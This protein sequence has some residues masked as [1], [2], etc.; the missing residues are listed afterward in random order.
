MGIVLTM[1]ERF[2]EA[3]KDKGLS[4]QDVTNAT[5]VHKSMIS[6]LENEPKD[7]K[8]RDVGYSNIV[9]LA[10]FYGVSIDWLL[11]I[12]DV[13][14]PEINLQSACKYT[15]LTEKTIAE[16]RKLCV[17]G[18]FN[19]ENEFS[20]LLEVLF[21]NGTFRF[22]LDELF[23]FYI[24]LSAMQLDTHIYT[25]ITDHYTGGR[26]FLRM[27]QGDT[28]RCANLAREEYRNRIDDILKTVNVSNRVKACIHASNANIEKDNAPTG[29][30]F[31]DHLFGAD[32]Y[33][34]KQYKSLII[35]SIVSVLREFEHAKPFDSI[36]VPPKNQ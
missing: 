8:I 36:K 27:D 17:D 20:E 33:H 24:S 18:F 11:G 15:G 2:E 13:R 35:E 32:R 12:S 28:I 3:R 9:K 10:Q 25:E 22:L 19:D 14:S 23:A 4:I 6:A 29:V 7:G 1:Y 26:D 5:G 30:D 21:T 31:Y 16:I 34:I